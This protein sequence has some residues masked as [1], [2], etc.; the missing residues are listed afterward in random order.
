MSVDLI[1]NIFAG[2]GAY[3][4]WSLQLVKIHNDREEGTSYLTRELPFKPD[5]SIKSFLEEVAKRYI[6]EGKGILNKYQDVREYDG[7]SIANTIYYLNK[8]NDLIRDQY[9]A[10]MTVIASP[11][12]EVES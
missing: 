10:L 8:D 5:G 2:I 9:A 4:A 12:A 1:R 7:T 6:A 3:D 11:D